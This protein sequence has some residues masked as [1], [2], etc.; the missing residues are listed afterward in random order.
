MKNFAEYSV[1]D[2]ATEPL[3]IQWVQQPHDAELSNFWQVWLK[4]HPDKLYEVSQAKV[5]VNHVS[6][7]YEDL[8]QA[9]VMTL[10]RRIAKSVDSFGTLTTAPFSYFYVL[11]WLA[12][13]LIVIGIGWM[14]FR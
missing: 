12:F 4:N 14:M 6:G 1:E 2:F 8:D 5:I 9:E 10:W 3:F 7:V 11:S 13:L